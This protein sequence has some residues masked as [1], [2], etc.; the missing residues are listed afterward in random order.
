MRHTRMQVV[1]RPGPYICAELEFGGLPAW[2]LAEGPI[3]LRTMAQPYISHVERWCVVFVGVVVVV[4]VA[5]VVV[6]V[7]V[8]VGYSY[9]SV[10]LL[11]LRRP[12]ILPSPCLSP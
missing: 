10:L 12:V 5:V 3:Q 9:T 8:R 4:V 7:L 6:A 11:A 1:L 2:L